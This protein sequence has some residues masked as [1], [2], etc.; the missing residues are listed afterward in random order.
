MYPV[1]VNVAPH[2]VNSNSLES[3]NGAQCASMYKLD[4]TG[5]TTGDGNTHDLRAALRLPFLDRFHRRKL[6]PIGKALLTAKK[7]RRG[8]ISAP[9]PRRRSPSSERFMLPRSWST[10][11]AFRQEKT[12]PWY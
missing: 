1:N 8:K 7:A 2:S 11:G 3:L 6:H 12:H 10:P 4:S 5:V 9:A